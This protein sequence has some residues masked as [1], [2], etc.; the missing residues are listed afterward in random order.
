METLALRA[1]ESQ[2]AERAVLTQRH[3][4]DGTDARGFGPEQ[5]IA[6]SVANLATARFARGEQCFERADVRVVGRQPA[7]ERLGVHV[8]Q[9]G[10]GAGEYERRVERV[11]V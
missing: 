3:E 7:Q 6:L 11:E 8:V 9:R 5:E 1:A 2:Q 10:D 4:R